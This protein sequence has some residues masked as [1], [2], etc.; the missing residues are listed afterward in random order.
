MSPEQQFES[1]FQYLLMTH[2][3]HSSLD[4]QSLT[5]QLSELS[6][7]AL[8]WPKFL[9]S[10]NHYV[11]TLTEMKQTAPLTGEIL[12]GPKPAP[13]PVPHQALTG[14]P[15]VDG[16]ILLAH[17]NATKEE[18]D[19][20]DRDWPLGGPE[21]N[22]KPPDPI[23]KSILLGHVQDSP[24]TAISKIYADALERPDW[25][26]TTI[27]DKIKI[28]ADN[29]N[30][31]LGSNGR[32]PHTPSPPR[33]SSTTTIPSDSSTAFLIRQIKELQK[34][35]PPVTIPRSAR[36]ATD[37]MTPGTAHPRSVTSPAALSEPSLPLKHGNNTTSRPTPV[38]KIP[39]EDAATGKDGAGEE[40]AAAAEAVPAVEDPQL[41]A[42]AIPVESIALSRST[43]I[44][45]G[46]TAPLPSTI[47]TDVCATIVTTIT[48]PRRAPLRRVPMRYGEPKSTSVPTRT[49]N[50]LTSPSTPPRIHRSFI[51]IT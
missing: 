18:Q 8:G 47:S 41:N 2:G 15:A 26:W 33:G 32:G 3:P 24:N 9:L 4:V 12:R 31:G 1:I 5:A 35:H 20:V 40:D 7:T 10:F 6:P 49:K 14:D 39:A 27:Y 50:Q 44:P 36:T 17:Y 23:I 45:V 46:S 37:R 51:Y 11:T 38:Q 48:R 28:V 16:P 21:L 13:V 25:S 22:Y 42:A 29:L 34:S 19:K 43:T 30:D